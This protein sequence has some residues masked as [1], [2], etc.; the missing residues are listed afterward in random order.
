MKLK[1]YLKIFK[2]HCE[3]TYGKLVEFLG[4]VRENL[5]NIARN[6]LF[7]EEIL[8]MKEMLRHFNGIFNQF[9]GKRN[10]F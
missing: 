1:I 9:C 4:H 2:E 5:K 8:N 6:N 7:W 10:F 3:K